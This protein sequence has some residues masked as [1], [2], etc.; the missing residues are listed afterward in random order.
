[1]AGLALPK[2]RWLLAGGLAAGVW[3]VSQENDVPRPPA[4]VPVSKSL[5]SLPK[6]V[7]R[8]PPRPQNV[9]TG[10]I[11][12]PDAPRHLR[13][14]AIVNLRAKADIGA[15]IIKTLGPGQ[16]VRELARYGKWRLVMVGN[17]KGWVHSDYLGAT[18]P[19]LRRPTLPVLGQPAK[20]V[21]SAASNNP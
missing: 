2:L 14:T 6:T 12:K 18:T 15:K 3:V 21:K 10:S 9:V 4:R 19:P 1:M 20:P 13:T 17:E 7:E 8:P 11:S 5:L 16:S